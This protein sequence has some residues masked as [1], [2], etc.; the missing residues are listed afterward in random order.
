MRYARALAF[1]ALTVATSV[2]A[3]EDATPLFDYAIQ[4]PSA[5]PPYVDALRK[6]VDTL[7]SEIARHPPPAVGECAHTLGAS[8]FAQQ[9]EDLGVVRSNQGNYT[10]AIESFEKAI[11]CTPRAPNLYAQLAAELLHAGRRA[12]ARAAAERGA[13]IDRNNAALDSILMQL[14]LIDER[15][16]EVVSRL[17][18]MIA[19]EPDAERAA[20]YQCFL[21]LAQRRAGVREPVLA[22]GREYEKW[23]AAILDALQGARTEAEV[24]DE[25]RSEGNEQ[26]RREMLVE[27]LYYVGQQRLATGQREVARRYFAAAVNL[28][29]LYFIEHHLALA[30]LMKM[31]AAPAPENATTER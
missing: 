18:A 6:Q 30:E 1:T 2:A 24:V 17:R 26:R 13:A 9:Y 11:D 14:D 21:W 22:S 10:A 25:V 16:A 3:A 12:E 15:W 28:K 4:Q 5:N 29:V 7:E 8:R 23:P 31:R 27:A 19:N 20:Y